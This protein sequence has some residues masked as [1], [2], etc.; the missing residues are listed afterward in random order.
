MR[1]GRL[2]LKKVATIG[3]VAVLTAVIGGCMSINKS[4]LNQNEAPQP[5]EPIERPIIEPFEPK[6]LTSLKTLDDLFAAIAKQVPA[7]G[8]MFIDEQDNLAIYLT[9]L[10]PS[11]VIAAEAAIRDVFG[12]DE[13]LLQRSMRMLQGQYGFLQ[14]KAWYDR[15]APKVLAL[16]GVVL[17]DIDEAKNRLAIGMETL[18]IQSQVE[19]LL[20]RLGIPLEAVNIEET[21]PVEFELRNR[22]RP[23]VGGLQINFSSWICTLGVIAI[24]QGVQG[25]VTNSHC[26]NIQGGVEGTVYHQP[27][28]SGITNRVGLEIA[29][30]RYFTGWPCPSGRRCR[31]SDSA[32]VRVPHPSGPATSV[33]RGY[34]ARTPYG[35]YTW[36]GISRYRITSELLSGSPLVGTPVTKVGRTTGRTSGTVTRA[37]VSIN[38]LNT[39][40]T[41]LCQNQASYSS[42][43]GDSGSPVFRITNSP[44]TNDVRI[45]GIHWGSGGAFSSTGTVG[46]QRSTELGFIYM[47][48]PGFSC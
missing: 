4:G 42:S 2:L 24:R 27:L 22:R 32:F 13:H 5:I 1:A 20:A 39:N 36:D 19:S 46:V 31:Y 40:I 35:S 30:P 14:L 38:V 18:G 17:T 16:P 26:T 29:D 9:D 7:F 23:L 21:K 41:L 12:A 11:V 37:C 45:I 10:S 28:A 34:I 44:S 47:C 33:N 43:P 15:M 25:F 8:G 6:E 3:L 48:A